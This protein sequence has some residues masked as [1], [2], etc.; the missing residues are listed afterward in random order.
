MRYHNNGQVFW[1]AT[2]LYLCFALQMDAATAE[3]NPTGSTIA[4][5]P[6]ILVIYA[7]D[8]SSPMS[9]CAKS[10]PKERLPNGADR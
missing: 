3:N 6:N 2:L 4:T 1:G 7:D 10:I 9:I 5:R 8:Q